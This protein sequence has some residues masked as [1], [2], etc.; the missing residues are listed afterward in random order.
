MDP[1]EM[2]WRTFLFY[3][4]DGKQNADN[5]PALWSAPTDDD[6]CVLDVACMTLKKTPM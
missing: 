4:C 2:T 5:A 1:E 3:E 6:P